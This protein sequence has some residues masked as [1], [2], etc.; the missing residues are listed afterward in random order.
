MSRN[1]ELKLD[2]EGKPVAVLNGRGDLYASI[3][4]TEDSNRVVLRIDD[5]FRPDFWV[6]IAIN[7]AALEAE[8]IA[9]K[10]KDFLPSNYCGECGEPIPEGRLFCD[11]CNNEDVEPLE[12]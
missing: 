5:A 1:V 9:R 2:G 10:A 8:V 11:D 6:E 3:R 12:D 4:S 7:L